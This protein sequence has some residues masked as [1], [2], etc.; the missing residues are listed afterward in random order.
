M[1]K[2]AEVLINALDY[3]EENIASD[4]MISAIADECLGYLIFYGTQ[5]AKN[6]VKYNELAVLVDDTAESKEYS[7]TLVQDEEEELKVLKKYEAVYQKNK[8]IVGLKQ[9]EI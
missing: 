2:N 6:E 9:E 8:K 5:Y 3:I 7:I 4:I 1:A